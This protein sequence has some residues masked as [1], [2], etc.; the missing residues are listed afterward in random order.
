MMLQLLKKFRAIS[1]K[2][3]HVLPSVANLLGS[4]IGDVT[5]TE[6]ALPVKLENLLLLGKRL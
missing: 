6:C 2:I 1:P 3:V 4:P 5:A